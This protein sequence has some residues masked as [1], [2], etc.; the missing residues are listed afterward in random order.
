M[1][2]A[3]TNFSWLSSGDR[4][5]LKMALNSANEFPAT[6]DPWS[7][8]CMIDL[9]KEKGC[10]EILVGDHS[11]IYQP[12]STRTCFQQTGLMDVINEKGATAV[13][14]N[15]ASAGGHMS[16]TAA[17]WSRNI[18]ITNVVNQVDHIIYMPRVATHSLADKTFGLK[19]AVGFLNPESRQLMH[20]G[21]INNLFNSINDVVEIKNKFRLSVFSARKLMTTG[22]P[23]SGTIVEPDHGLIFASEDLLAADLMAG[24]FL[25]VNRGTDN[26]IYCHDPLQSYVQRNGNIE[27]LLWNTLNENP[28]NSIT[29]K[30]INV[31][32]KVA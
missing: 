18:N 21:N 16:V 27:A 32:Q 20:S 23:D 24:A 12:N 28:D 2:E 17:N 29:D 6:T 22:G 9:L 4:I 1:L 5:L 25:E 30:M 31:L 3:V 7:L 10:G 8:A 14:F 11:G 15:E 19:L 13:C 26:D